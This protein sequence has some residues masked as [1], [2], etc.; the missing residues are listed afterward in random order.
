MLSTHTFSSA[1][2]ETLQLSMLSPQLT[3]MLRA[4]LIKHYETS[5]I[6]ASDD[7]REALDALYSINDNEMYTVV[8]F[9]FEDEYT[10]FLLPAQDLTPHSV[11]KS[12]IKRLKAENDYTGEETR[13]MVTSLVETAQTLHELLAIQKRSTRRAVGHNGNNEIE[14]P[15]M[16]VMKKF[17]ECGRKARY[18]SVEE[19]QNDL[20]KDNHVYS[21]VHCGGLHQGRQPTGFAVPQDIREGRYT[22]AWR[23]YNHI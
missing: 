8:S 16:E 17:Y 10:F 5:I 4:D 14:L 15:S 11:T 12:L 6:M 21:C 7:Y 20:G 3:S 22:T 13:E 18:S 2:E 23:R 1:I 19:V 9:C